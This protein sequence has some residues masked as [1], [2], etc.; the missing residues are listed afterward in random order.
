MS[1][2]STL[3]YH[4]HWCQT[5]VPPHQPG[6]VDFAET[7]ETEN[8]NGNTE[9]ETRKVLRMLTSAL[10]LVDLTSASVPRRRS[11]IRVIVQLAHSCTRCLVTKTALLFLRDPL[12]GRMK[13]CCLCRS[14]GSELRRLLPYTLRVEVSLVL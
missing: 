7:T 1:T 12:L 4:Q 3:N 8:G 9:T 11:L 5:A 10:Y 13:T 6:Q 2:T 14:N